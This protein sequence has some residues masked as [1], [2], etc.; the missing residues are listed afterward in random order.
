[1]IDTTALIGNVSLVD[2]I[3]FIVLFWVTVFVAK[4]L[5]LLVKNFLRRKTKGTSYKIVAKIINYSLIFSVTYF[6]LKYILGFDL[7]ALVAS[8]GIIGIAIAFSAQQVAQNLIGGIFILTGGIIKLGEWIEL[9]GLPNTELCM[10]KDISLTKTKLREHNGR[11]VFIPN[12]VF[13]TNKIV[14]YQEGDFFKFP[15]ELNV[16]RN[17]NLEEV[18]KIIIE[19]CNKN[20]KVLPNIPQKEKYGLRKIL[21]NVSDEDESLLKF[22]RRTIDPKIFEPVVFVKN[23]GENDIKLEVWIWL[24]DISEKENIVSDIMENLL[25]E[26]SKNKIKL[27]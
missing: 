3:L 12:S 9:P 5:S 11:I 14:K 15:F 16:S 24:W 21:K 10:V 2:I 19:V 4:T 23:I 13:I 26:F 25:K 20:E 8:F 18:K 6:G 7:T 1:M 22:L 17:N 27:I